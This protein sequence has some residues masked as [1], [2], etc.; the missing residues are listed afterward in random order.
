M[1]RNSGSLVGKRYLFFLRHYNDIDN[2][3][4]AIYYFLEESD[5]HIADVVLYDGSY[6]Y[7]DNEN[8]EFLKTIYGERFTYKWLGEY[9]G[10]NPENYFRSKVLATNKK[11]K[12]NLFIPIMNLFKNLLKSILKMVN[13]SASDIRAKIARVKTLGKNNIGE[14]IDVGRLCRGEND[15]NEI[16]DS[17]IK[18][19][20]F[21]SLL[22][23]LVIFDINRTPEIKGLLFSLRKY[24]VKR[25]ICLPVSPLIS[26]N[27][28]RQEKLIDLRSEQFYRLHDYS[29]FDA[30][31][32]VDNYF[33]DSYSRTFKLLGIEST[34]KGKTKTL[35]SIRYCPAWLKKRDQ[36]IKPF[37]L[38]T[39][40]IKS[41]LFLSNP[42]SNV[43]WAE[44]ERVL[45]FFLNYPEYNLVVKHHTR[46]QI[47]QDQAKF[48][49]INFVDNIN[50]SALIDWA[51]V[52]LFWS[53]SVAIEGY[54]KNKVMVCLS[55]VSG[56]RNLYEL[57]DAGFIVRCR[58]DLHEF[59]HLYYKSKNKLRYNNEGV[60]KL[61]DR[62]ILPGGDKVVNNYL[63][64]MR[65]NE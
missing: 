2:I 3:A 49:H 32:Y 42:L 65:E 57:H 52:V 13:L 5:D 39:E 22:P 47:K 54:V 56:N 7:R 33:V 44:V 19:I 34:L 11:A 21:R 48:P 20:L 35:G 38:D 16:T 15:S 40:K 64:Y 1:E 59:L 58:D 25:I 10:I 8:L 14:N 51:D 53:T 55:Y 18:K 37:F 17:V 62:T 29:G 31:G 24:G 41:V 27:T 46:S 26:Y 60:E 9:L 50:S 23:N 30:V 61:L 45:Y 4:P 6:D 63:T 28:L 12:T 43:N 36:Y